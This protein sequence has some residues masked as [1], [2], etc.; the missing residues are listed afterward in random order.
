MRV[1][2]RPLLLSGCI[3]LALAGCGDSSDDGANGSG[4]PPLTQAERAEIDARVSQNDAQARFVAEHPDAASA[5][6]GWTVEGDSLTARFEASAFECDGP[7]TGEVAEF[8]ILE[9]GDERLVVELEGERMEWQRVS[10]DGG[11]SG[12]EGTWQADA[13]DGGF[14]ITFAPDGSLVASA[15]AETDCAADAD[16]SYFTEDGCL[17]TELPRT[18]TITIDGNLDDWGGDDV[19]NMVDATDD[20]SSEMTGDEI[21]ELRMAAD[22][23]NLYVLLTLNE[24]VNSSFQRGS[25]D[26]AGSYDIVVRT[27]GG[28]GSTRDLT[29]VYSPFD[30]AWTLMGFSPNDGSYSIAAGDQSFELRVSWELFGNPTQIYQV[31][32]F[33]RD[34][35]AGPECVVYDRGPCF[36]EAGDTRQ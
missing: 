22:A 36:A 35:S 32:T 17:V 25:E 11:E 20:S 31:D 14:L 15:V 3:V 9:Q 4:P 26:T 27:D 28:G 7:Q 18:R 6:G 10:G 33:A 34:C 29:I 16:Q 30:Q 24:P 1:S 2:P 21:R 23:D 12:V 8:R 5:V 13:D 19:I